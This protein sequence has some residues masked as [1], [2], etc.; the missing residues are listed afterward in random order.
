[1]KNKTASVEIDSYS[2]HWSQLKG[3][4]IYVKPSFID[5]GPEQK[6]ALSLLRGK[7]RQYLT[8]LDDSTPVVKMVPE[9]VVSWGLG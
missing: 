7:Y 4:L 6:R 9:D 5:T 1:M 2:D 3:V 8:M